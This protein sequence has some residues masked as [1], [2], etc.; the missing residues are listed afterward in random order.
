ME[1]QVNTSTN[2]DEV[3]LALDAEID[4]AQATAQRARWTRW[5]LIAALATLG[6]L[7]LDVAQHATSPLHLSAVLTVFLA[8]QTTFDGASGLEGIG[9]PADRVGWCARASDFGAQ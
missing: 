7:S 9:R 4:Y 8:L 2:R 6:W 3:I 5:A 1:D